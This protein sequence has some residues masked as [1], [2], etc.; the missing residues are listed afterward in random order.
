MNDDEMFKE[1]IAGNSLLDVVRNF[2]KQLEPYQPVLDSIVRNSNITQTPE[3]IDYVF[4]TGINKGRIII[5]VGYLWKLKEKGEDENTLFKIASDS[6]ILYSIHKWINQQGGWST[7]VYTPITYQIL[8][9]M[10]GWF[11]KL[12]WE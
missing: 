6:F 3:I 10:F 5:V 2:R 12:K 4:R 1:I 9:C 8:N 7:F 11:Y